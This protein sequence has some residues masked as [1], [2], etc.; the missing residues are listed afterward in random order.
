MC[1]GAENWWTG[2]LRPCRKLPPKATASPILA[3]DLAEA[4]RLGLTLN[5]LTEFFGL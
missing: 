4:R 3:E 5:G 1:G 2:Q